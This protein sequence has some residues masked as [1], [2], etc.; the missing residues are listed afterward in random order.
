M[1][2]QSKNLK[3][4]ERRV[5]LV[6]SWKGLAIGATIGSVVASVWAGLDW[7][8]L[9]LA[10][11]S[12]LGMVVGAGAVL[13]AAIGILMRVSPKSLADSIDRRAELEDRL[14]TSIERRESEAGFD[15]ALH[16]DA[17]AHLQGLKP[18]KLYP[19]RM[20]RWQGA[21][22]V[23]AALASGIFLLGNTPILLSDQQK[24]DRAEVK[25]AGETIE[26]VLKPME[27]HPELPAQAAEDKR[28]QEAMR[29]LSRELE[30]SKLTKEEAMQKANELQKQA[31]ELVKERAQ[32][33]E[34][35]LAKAE[36]A[37]E[38]M[39]KAELEKNGLKDVDPELAKLSDAERQSKM[40]ENQKQSDALKQQISQLQSQMVQQQSQQQQMQLSKELQDLLKKQ[41][42]LSKQMEQLKLSK[43]V[44]EMLKRMMENPLYKK[45]LEMQQKLEKA[46]QE[47]QKNGEQQALTHEQI[48]EMQKQLEE[49]AKQL[50]DDKGMTEYLQKLIDAMKQGCST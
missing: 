46:M 34:Q 31:Q 29:R 9:A 2:E 14:V 24:K 21:A 48:E 49:L 10:E 15:A 4:F 23:L 11:W 35:T 42:E 45:L 7:A 1:T 20:G 8:N 47:A 12:E 37:F 30:R 5:R 40:D 18:A 33:T 25:K 17:Q 39:E 38:K 27:D 43:Q 13:G 41:S 6:R 44:Q 50:K 3:R 19:V 32:T 36:S 22:I 16:A 26:H 28:M